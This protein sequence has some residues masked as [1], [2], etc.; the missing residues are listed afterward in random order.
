MTN[1]VK[2]LVETICIITRNQYFLD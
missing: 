1:D 2:D